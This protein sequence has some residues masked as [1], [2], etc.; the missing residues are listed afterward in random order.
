MRSPTPRRER[1]M[2]YGGPGSSK[3]RSWM[4]IADMYRK[5]KT[6]G[7]FYVLDTDDA[8]WANVEEFPELASAGICVVNYVF[9]WEG[10]MEVA[11]EYAFKAQPGDW[12]IAD[13]FDKGWEEVQNYYSNQVFGA[14]KGDY[15]LEK[16]KE[17]E[18]RKKKASN[19]QAFEGWVDWT[20]IKPLHQQ[21]TNEI[22]FRNKA[23]VYLACTQKPVARG[24][25]GREIVDTFGH[26]G[27]KPGGEKSIGVHGANTVLKFIDKGDG[28]WA[29]DTGKDRGAREKMSGVRNNN[30]ALDYLLNPKRGGWL[31][32]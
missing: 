30:F 31:L 25:D 28:E 27:S 6:E 16:R 4:T 22:I 23:H 15:F 18:E 1:I 13:L 7:T 12:I 2:V 5:T 21:W 17:M 20:V 9:E 29:M 11:R 32:Q 8:Y 10:Y 19:F 26:L 24:Q 14:D 3:T